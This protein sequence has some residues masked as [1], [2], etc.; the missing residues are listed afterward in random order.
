MLRMIAYCAES[1]KEITLILLKSIFILPRF[2]YKH[3]CISKQVSYLWNRR[4]TRNVLCSLKWFYLFLL[5]CKH[6]QMASNITENILFF[7][8]YLRVSKIYGI[9]SVVENPTVWTDFQGLREN[10]NQTVVRIETMPDI[11]IFE[12]WYHYHIN[13]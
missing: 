2:F 4:R 3:T 9:S 5:L 13:L 8:A 6:F 11:A 7:Q 10:K 1:I 12:A